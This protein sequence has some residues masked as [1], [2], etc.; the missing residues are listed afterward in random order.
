MAKP[1]P[2]ALVKAVLSRD[3][4]ICQCCGRRGANIHHIVFGGTG[5]KRIHIK[6]NLITLCLDCHR[7][8][9]SSKEMR[10]WTYDW[11]R[12]KYGDKVDKL[13]QEKWSNE[14]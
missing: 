14:K 13:L 12:K 10:E 2:K 11:S 5:R 9:H 6:E 8:A 7:E 1:I 4:E 3:N